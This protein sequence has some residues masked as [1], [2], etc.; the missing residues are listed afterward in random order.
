MAEVSRGHSSPTRNQERPRA[1]PC[2][3]RM[4][5]R[6]EGAAGRPVHLMSARRPNQQLMLPFASEEPGEA[7]AKRPQGV[8]A[9]RTVEG[10]ES[11]V[12]SNDSLMEV[13]CSSSNIQQA[14]RRVAANPGAAGIDGMSVGDLAAHVAHHGSEI[15]SLWT[16]LGL[17]NLQST[18]RALTT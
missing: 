7:R 14:L 13:I 10:T 15:K 8:E 17:L 3:G 16:K 18:G 1:N 5:A 4:K 2:I 9:P 11:P 6:T 12:S